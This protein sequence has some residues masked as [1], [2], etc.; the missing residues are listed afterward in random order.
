MKENDLRLSFSN[1]PSDLNV[2][3]IDSLLKKAQLLNNMPDYDLVIETGDNK[4][5]LFILFSYDKIDI[6]EFFKPETSETIRLWNY[7]NSLNIE[8]RDLIR[9][10]IYDVMG[11]KI[12]E[13]VI[14]GNSYNTKL[15]LNNGIYI[16]RAYSKTGSKTEKLKIS[17]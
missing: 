1:I 13:E 2:Y 15:D 8:G 10:E 4:G 14:S 16:V 17:N 6:N 7:N 5:R 12:L 9:F 11:N 3:L